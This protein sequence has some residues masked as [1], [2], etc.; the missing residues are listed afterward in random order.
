MDLYA[1]NILDHYRNPRGQKKL[2]DPSVIHREENTSC[3]DELTIELKIENDIITE[4]TWTGTGCA[5]S[6]AAI[7]L[8]SE[9]V[10]GIKIE[11]ANHLSK[12]K[13]EALLGVPVGIRRMKC[14]LLCL[15]TLK[16]TLR[17]YV[18]EEAQSWTKTSEVED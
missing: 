14:A 6:Q 12:E 5:I 4:M 9:E 11:E 8:L 10:E 16:N 7:S 1:E 15:H 18:G 17:K 2:A 3:G 13:I